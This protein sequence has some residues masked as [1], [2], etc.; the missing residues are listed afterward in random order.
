MEVA[1]ATTLIYEALKTVLRASR[2]PPDEPDCP[3]AFVAPPRET[4]H[5][6]FDGAARVRSQTIA[7]SR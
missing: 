2:Y 3:M 5:P 6:T 7:R 1:D 4:F